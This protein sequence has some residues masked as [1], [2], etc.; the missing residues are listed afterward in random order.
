MP[1]DLSTQ[2]RSATVLG[3]QLTVHD[4]ERDFAAGI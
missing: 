3:R 4:H 1:V 2:L